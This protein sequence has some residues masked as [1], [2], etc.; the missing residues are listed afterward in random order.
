MQGWVLP[1]LR[2]A[3]I[4]P[5][6]LVTNSWKQSVTHTHTNTHTRT[7]TRTHT[8][9]HTH[10]HTQHL[11]FCSKNG[12]AGRGAWWGAVGVIYIFWL[13][14]LPWQKCLH[15]TQ[16]GSEQD[17]GFL[18]GRCSRALANFHFLPTIESHLGIIAWPCQ[19][20]TACIF[21]ELFQNHLNIS[22]R[23]GR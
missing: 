8:H 11:H 2:Q 12:T 17:G 9:T 7:H 15:T 16:T 21:P 20:L 22:E 6:W 13:V 4:I 3:W 5:R 14:G 19:V 10:A 18:F 1:A 23:L